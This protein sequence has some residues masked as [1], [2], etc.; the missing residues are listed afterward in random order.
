M[1]DKV[2]CDCCK[3]SFNRNECRNRLLDEIKMIFDPFKYICLECLT[4]I[5][6]EST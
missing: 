2:V 3:K 1:S 5:Y 6:N 4:K